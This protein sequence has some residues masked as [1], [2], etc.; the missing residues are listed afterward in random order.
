[1]K[2]FAPES[3]R[4]IAVDLDG[5]LIT[6]QKEVTERTQRAIA[7]C[8]RRGILFAF[9]TGR[10][11]GHARR[12]AEL[13]RPDAALLNYG[14][15]I[16]VRGETLLDKYMS[17]RV[18]NAVREAALGARRIRYGLENDAHYDEDPV[19]GDLPLDRN[20]PFASRVAYLSAWDLPEDEARAISARC[21]CALTQIVGSRW[22]NFGP[23][24]TGKGA[25]MA[26]LMRALGLTPGQ[27]VGF[28]DEDCDIAFFRACGCGVAMANGDER[29][30]RAA[31]FITES[32]E[33]DGVAVFLEQYILSDH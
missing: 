12:Y 26:R 21:G 28:G 5:T 24:G 2:A 1:M 19:S 22:C 33:M 30:R 15:N 6:R 16:I 31:D 9:A 20:A 3:I 4:L 23:R 18:A 14:A 8:R 29:T 32:N 17:P 13:L 11:R 7:A 25:G 10:C 27:A